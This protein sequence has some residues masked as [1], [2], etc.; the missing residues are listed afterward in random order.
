M[1]NSSSLGHFEQLVLLCTYVLSGNG[2]GV[3]ITREVNDRAGRQVLLGSVYV[4]LSRLEERGLVASNFSLPTAARGGR[5]KRLFQVT[6]EGLQALYDARSQAQMLLDE[7][8]DL[9]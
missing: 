7:L 8:P 2:Y 1:E 3:S 4:T 6:P 9:S 5:S